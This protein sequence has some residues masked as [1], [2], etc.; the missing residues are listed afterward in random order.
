VIRSALGAVLAALALAACTSSGDH[1][2]ASGASSRS[3]SRP[4]VTHPVPLLPARARDV[5]RQAR[6][7]SYE[8][9]RLAFALPPAA[10]LDP[11]FIPG[12]AKL[13]EFNV[14]DAHFVQ[15]DDSTATVPVSVVDAAGAPSTWTA[16][17]VLNGGQWL[18]AG[19]EKAA[20]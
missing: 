19:S 12:L 15:V 14:D 2:L 5:E 1:P 9:V 6:S 20:S 10:K 13:R 4:V 8:Q 17:L 16:D 7:G 18:I 3:A 11:A